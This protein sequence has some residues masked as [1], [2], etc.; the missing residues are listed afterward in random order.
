MQTTLLKPEQR[1][2]VENILRALSSQR[3]RP[4]EEPRACTNTYFLRG[5]IDWKSY[6]LIRTKDKRN[7]VIDVTYK[8]VS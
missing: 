5:L 1:G 6:F 3:Q 4:K 2:F 7:P 8:D